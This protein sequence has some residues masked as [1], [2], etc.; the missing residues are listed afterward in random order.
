V[1]IGIGYSWA[2]V[3]IG[4][5]TAI[6]LRG[7]N[8][9]W[10]WGRNESG[11]LGQNNTIDRSSPVQ[12]PGSW[13]QIAM[14]G[15]GSLLA[16]KT[17][18]TM[19]AWGWNNYGQLGQNDTISRSSPVQVSAGYPGAV[20]LTGSSSSVSTT[21]INF[22]TGLFTVEGWFYRTSAVGTNTTF[23]GST[24]GTGV[25]PKIIFNQMNTGELR[26]YHTAGDATLTNSTT[27]VPQNTWVH[28]AVVRDAVAPAG[29]KI[30]V[31]G[32]LQSSTT[33]ASSDYSGITGTFNI[34][35]DGESAYAFFPGSISNFRVVTGV[36]VY[37]GNFSVSKSPLQ[38]TQ[39]AGTNISAITQYQTQLLVASNAPNLYDASLS[40]RPLTLTN[41][42]YSANSPISHSFSQIVGTYLSLYA[43]SATDNTLWGWGFNGQGQIADGTTVQ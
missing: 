13:S 4:T 28:I 19:W 30:Y 14:A 25:T 32:Q 40:H 20:V 15:I 39:S 5:S 36:A 35:A 8:T 7:D 10:V 12:V 38:I 41:A 23:W 18:S 37:T 21:N 26:V 11:Q 3:H 29:I 42:T 1:Q 34:G 33:N 2:D 16:I 24:N 17:D 43:K 9:L 27:L 31:N 22:G 6:A